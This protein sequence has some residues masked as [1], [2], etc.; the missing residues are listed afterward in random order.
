MVGFSGISTLYTKGTQ[1]ALVHFEGKSGNKSSGKKKLTGTPGQATQSA[2][3]T[4]K[5]SAAHSDTS[6]AVTLPTPPQ[7]DQ[8]TLRAKSPIRDG[9]VKSPQTQPPVSSQTTK[10]THERPSLLGGFL[11]PHIKSTLSPEQAENVRTRQAKTLQK[12]TAQ[13]SKAIHKPLGKQASG[14]SPLQRALIKDAKKKELLANA[15]DGFTLHNVSSA[16]SLSSTGSKVPSIQ[17]DY[18]DVKD[19]EVLSTPSSGLRTPES[20]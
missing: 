19:F 8:M 16:E 17:D 3:P 9:G 15:N 4:P 18:D 2:T 11:G 14:E 6:P 5:Q 20:K 10:K 7:H 1:G 13:R 12:V